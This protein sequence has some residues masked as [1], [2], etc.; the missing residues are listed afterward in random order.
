MKVNNQDILKEMI[1]YGCFMIF[2]GLILA[3]ITGYALDYI[4]SELKLKRKK[5]HAK[6]KMDSPR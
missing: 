4:Y 6:N 5:H 3:Q 1:Q 2:G